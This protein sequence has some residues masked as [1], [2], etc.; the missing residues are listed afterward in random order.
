MN[1]W[2][3]CEWFNIYL[4]F[5]SW[6]TGVYKNYSVNNIKYS[7]NFI[8]NCVHLKKEKKAKLELL[9][10]FGV[11]NIFGFVLFFLFNSCHVLWRPWPV[12]IW[13]N[14]K[15]K[16]LVLSVYFSYH[17]RTSNIYNC[18]LHS[19]DTQVKYVVQLVKS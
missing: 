17:S 18:S 13:I 12:C 2:K 10:D 9:G 8:L 6:N 11:R 3:I 16:C 7:L 5:F 15:G 19:Q 4:Y 1:F 14:W